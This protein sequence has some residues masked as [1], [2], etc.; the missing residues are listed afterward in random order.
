MSGVMSMST[1]VLVALVSAARIGKEGPTVR[2]YD[3]PGGTMS[4][5]QMALLSLLAA[6]M[7]TVVIAL[8]PRYA[9]PPPMPTDGSAPPLPPPIQVGPGRIP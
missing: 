6:M 4:K 3:L 8:S 2:H 1:F 7:W 9:V 5:I